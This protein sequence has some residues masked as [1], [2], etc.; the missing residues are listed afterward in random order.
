M[1][2]EYKAMAFEEHDTP[3]RFAVRIGNNTGW[4]APG[5]DVLSFASVEDKAHFLAGDHSEAC[6]ARFI[7]VKG[8]SSE[9]AK[10]DLRDNALIAARKY[11]DKYFLYRIFERN[12]GY[13]EF[14]T[15]KNPLAD[16]T[17]VNAFYEVNLE[18]ATRT[19]AFNL[20]GG[21]SE[22]SYLKQFAAE[23]SEPD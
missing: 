3:P 13:Y 10:I 21:L 4:Q 8:R 20:M 17:G 14:A 2:C 15:L 11:K 18:A 5:V 19:E 1:F 23:L 9:G 16:E 6:I 12:D 22:D 7:E